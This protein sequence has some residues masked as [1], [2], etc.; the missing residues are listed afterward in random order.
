MREFLR[1]YY[2]LY[3]I[4]LAGL[5][6]LIS[7]I[8]L[9]N[10]LRK[11]IKE[12]ENMGTTSNE[13]LMT[14]KRKYEAGA[15]VNR[16]IR[17]V[18]VFV[19]RYLLRYQTGGF[20]L[21]KLGSVTYEMMLCVMIMGCVGG[22]GSYFENL[23]VRHIVMYPAGAVMIVM[24]LLFC[25]AFLEIENKMEQLKL[26]ILDYLENTMDARMKIRSESMRILEKQGQKETPELG[27]MTVA[28]A[29]DSPEEERL[30]QEVLDEYLT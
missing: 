28:L 26:L 14:L 17:N 22:V 30:V 29:F 4:M 5:T 12:A 9:S 13:L 25:E 16:S 18:D 10:I 6:G 24:L 21:K 3:A 7:R 23:G 27:E 2:L 15:K 1:N 8:A 11:L 20:T 19:Q